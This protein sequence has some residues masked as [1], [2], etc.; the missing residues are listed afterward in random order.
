MNA[1]M[2][3]ASPIAIATVKMSSTFPQLFTA[4][5][6][7][8]VAAPA[9]QY[10]KPRPFHKKPREDGPGGKPDFKAKSDYKGKGEFKGKPDF[11]A[12]SEFKPKGEFKSKGEFKPKGEYKPKGE[13]KAGADFK[14][15]TEA[16]PE[17]RSKLFLKAGAGGDRPLIKKRR[18]RPA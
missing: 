7:M 15:K 11:K 5:N 8:L 16:K 4:D 9:R 6:E 18:E 2:S 3:R 13:F 12:K 10:D 14:A 17:A 1:W